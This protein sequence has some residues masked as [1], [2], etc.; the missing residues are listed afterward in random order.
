MY[1]IRKEFTF[2]ASHVLNGLVE[3]HKCGR[4]HGHTYTVTL[5]LESELLDDNGFVQDYGELN[6]I[7]NWIDITLDHRHL[8]EIVPGQPSAEN[9]A[10]WVYYQWKSQYPKLYAVEVKET[11]K[12]SARYVHSYR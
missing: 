9:I 11:P 10:K 2:D 8:N 5:E 4:L 12:T 7:K 3:G 6:A 1:T